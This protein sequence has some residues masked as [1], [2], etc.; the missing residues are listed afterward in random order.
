MNPRFCPPSEDQLPPGAAE[1]AEGPRDFFL[2][3]FHQNINQ[4]QA[5]PLPPSLR[6]FILQMTQTLNQ[7]DRGSC[8]QSEGENHLTFAAPSCSSTSAGSEFS[9]VPK[10]SLQNTRVDLTLSPVLLQP[11]EASFKAAPQIQGSRGQRMSG[12]RGKPSQWGCT[13]GWGKGRSPLPFSKQAAPVRQSPAP[14]H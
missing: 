7:L 1:R 12:Q 4:V 8:L 11:P 5:S 6:C 13:W 14:L 2:Q 10:T 9:E 3:V